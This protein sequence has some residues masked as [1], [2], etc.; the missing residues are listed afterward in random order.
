MNRMNNKKNISEQPMIISG[1][2]PELLSNQ[3][4]FSMR[5]MMGN[6][7][8]YRKFFYLSIIVFMMFGLLIAY[9]IKPNYQLDLLIKVEEKSSI[10]P[11]GALNQTQTPEFENTPAQ[12][13][14]D[15][16][17]SRKVITE[18]IDAT[19]ANIKIKPLNWFFSDWLENAFQ[20][21]QKNELP[22]KSNAKS[23]IVFKDL[24]LYKKDF[25][26]EF[27]LKIFKNNTW[28]LFNDANKQI[29]TGS[30]DGKEIESNDGILALS[31]SH[32]NAKEGSEFLIKTAPIL[33]MV[34][35]IQNRI[36]IEETKRLSGVL[37]V[38][39]QS[40]FPHKDKEVLN[41]IAKSY[42]ELNVNRR[43]LEAQ[44]SLE[45]LSKELP[46]LKVRLEDSEK[47]LNDFRNQKRTIDIP[48]EIKALIE[49]A[50]DLEKTKSELAL[51]KK[52]YETYY[53]SNYP[54]LKN[55]NAQLDG[56]R[57]TDDMIRVKIA[58][59]P[60][61]QQEYV[62]KVR[63]VEVNAELY[64]NLLYNAQQ[65]E[66][67]KAGTISSAS[68]IDYAEIPSKPLKSKR[69]YVIG[70]LIFGI[71]VGAVLC[72]FLAYFLGIIRDPKKL[73]LDIELPILGLIPVSNEQIQHDL[74]KSKVSK[75]DPFLMARE[76][77]LSEA[78]ESLRG[79]RSSLL[80]AL[81]EKEGAKTMM[82]TSAVAGQGKSFIA[83]NLAYLISS[84]GKK[85]LLIESDV[86]RSSFN[87]YL[88]LNNGVPGLSEYLKGNV[89]M[90]KI[91]QKSVYPNLDIVPSG[92]NI[93][94]PG[95]FFASDL[96]VNLIRELSNDY[97]YVVV[98]SPPAIPINDSRSFVSAIDLL[99]F[100]TRQELVSLGE[101]QDSIDSFEK[102]GKPVDF[103]IY[104]GYRDSLFHRGYVNSYMYTKN[105]YKDYYA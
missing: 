10:T 80:F 78:T 21:N 11:V 1:G 48:S 25:K 50:T 83:T 4:I 61:V 44:N 87:Y 98:D 12:G 40:K 56:L 63:D 31:I 19:R 37:R 62:R 105:K 82:V 41:A 49:Q 71:L 94:N 7:I 47:I 97:D 52:E 60:E 95:D 59:L 30:A 38:A 33:E 74:K 8:F 53:E 77:P 39:I 99:L 68:I 28:G 92:G 73:E 35:Q 22:S 102:V 43:R 29:A 67:A 104:N 9:L 64:K 5:E 57:K 34:E 70:S 20:A 79:L 88:A 100:V 24:K 6:L 65:L 55:I 17:R 58:A 32:L 26:S 18:A 89:L 81:S 14:I 51:K 66:I 2:T 85:V 91:I 13:E 96:M 15:I 75:K 36:K 27:K 45:F 42:V 46:I 90:N 16:I 101:V 3:E 103:I 54:M 86:R 76:A 23:L 69:Y 84:A 93:E 72:Q